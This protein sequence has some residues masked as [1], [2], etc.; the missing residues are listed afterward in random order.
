MCSSDE[1]YCFELGREIPTER[2]LRDR[3][4]GF[5]KYE[6]CLRLDDVLPCTH[7]QFVYFPLSDDLISSFDLTN[8]SSAL[9]NYIIRGASRCVARPLEELT[10][11]K[12]SG[13]EVT[14]LSHC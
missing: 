12:T 8:L 4:A 7:R 10:L 1:V 11:A 3:H 5:D 9:E 14:Y 6:G 13:A 2:I